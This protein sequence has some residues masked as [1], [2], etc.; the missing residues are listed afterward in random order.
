MAAFNFPDPALEQTT[1]NPITGSTY[2]WK[3]PPGKWVIT[4]K[5]RQITDIIYE[6]DLPPDP[7]GDYK[8]WYSTDT[9]E[10]YFW[11][12]DINGVGA[13][14]PTSAPI[15]MLED[16]DTGLSEVK[17]GLVA[18]NVAI[19]E[20]TNRIESIVYFG[21]E[22]PTIYPDVDTG[23]TTP[24][25]TDE[26]A[27]VFEQDER[28]YKFWLDTDND[29][30]SILRIDETA[31]SG[32]SY[33]AVVN[34]E[35]VDRIEDLE[36][37]V[38]RQ[39]EDIFKGP[40]V[41]TADKIP[42]DGLWNFEEDEGTWNTE[43]D[44]YLGIKDIDGETHIYGD[45]EQGDILTIREDENN[46]ATYVIKKIKEEED[47][48]IDYIE[49]RID[50]VLTY[51]GVPHDGASAK[52]SVV[53]KLD[54]EVM[55]LQA[56]LTAG[57]IAD[58]GIVL[59][60]ATDDALLLS[61]EEARIM[62]GGVGENVVPR[63]ELRHQTGILE[64][65]IVKLELDE[66]GKRFDIECDEKVDNIHFRF[67]NDDK[68]VLNKKGDAAFTGKVQVEPGI[69]GNEAVTYN[70]LI[71][72]EEQIEELA[73]SFERG[74]W[75]FTPEYPPGF[76]EYTMIKEGLDEDA[77]EELCTQAFAECQLANQDDPVALADC[78]RDF[79][80]CMDS[81]NGTKYL[82]TEHWF[83]STRIVFSSKDKNGVTHRWNDIAP[84][85]YIEVF[86]IDGTGGMVSEITKKNYQ[87]DIFHM[88]DRGIGQANGLAAVKIYTLN[89]SENLELQ[90]TPAPFAWIFKKTSSLPGNGEMTCS[91]EAP[92][93]GSFIKL[94]HTTSN[95]IQFSRRRSM[96]YFSSSE[97]LPLITIWDK[98]DAGYRHKL[99][100]SVSKIEQDAEGNFVIK[101]GSIN[102]ADNHNITE[103]ATQ[104]V[105]VG[106]FF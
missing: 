30:L 3:E 48:G 27:P 31:A 77:Q 101:L 102:S 64:T 103:G 10:L 60:N 65:S 23:N 70:Q 33:K 54:E 21:P 45:A 8:L 20:N 95:N 28:N 24:D 106:G 68:L 11:F 36:D 35:I 63:L 88:A 32:Y 72:L 17:L 57:N 55:D 44:I 14:V 66:D 12:E 34:Q 18:A 75:E 84:G 62:V 81:I 79:N 41:K 51:K 80:T 86:N 100:A 74:R 37:A 4:T 97:N 25:G 53:K 87:G 56:V 7:R 46:Y 104:W 29:T 15:T 90:P 78:T 50:S 6:G 26:G 39:Q 52:I 76:G 40:W 96:R 105:T 59:T 92:S 82:T 67:A 93:Q 89:T 42:T 58:K 2:Q 99:S 91:T 9:L 98:V 85:L 71:L 5:L 19:N 69:E 73:P 49:I 13:W 61:P 94:S 47:D 83:E 22:P 1:V 38:N 43:D 16:L